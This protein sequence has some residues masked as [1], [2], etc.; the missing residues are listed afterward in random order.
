M[1][2]VDAYSRYTCIYFLQ[3]KSDAPETFVEFHVLAE[4]QLDHKMK[5]VQS[6][7]G[8]EFK[9]LCPYLA[10]LGILH[11]ITC[12]YTRQQNGMVERKRR[13]IV[14]LALTLLA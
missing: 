4:K 10:Q 2:I 8:E 7:G 11:R 3:E 9:F 12:H 13:R 1:S 5:A 14:E 6:D